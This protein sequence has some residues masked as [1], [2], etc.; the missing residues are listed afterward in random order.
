MAIYDLELGKV[1]EKIKEKK[2]K[3]VL[4]QLPDG[5]KPEAEKIVN[6]LQKETQT[7]VFIW[8]GDCFG[9]CDI[10]LGLQQFSIDLVIQWG[11]NTFIKEFGW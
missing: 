6:I 2:A 4:I 1:V 11:H 10:P 5:L 8:L 3:R 7:Q 9:A